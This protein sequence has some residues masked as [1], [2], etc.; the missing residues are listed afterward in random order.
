MAV[1]AH[2]NISALIEAVISDLSALILYGSDRCPNSAFT[3]H[4]SDR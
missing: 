3:H 1:M 2:V 4:G